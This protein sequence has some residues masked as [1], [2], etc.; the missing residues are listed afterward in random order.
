[1]KNIYF[2]AATAM[3][4]ISLSLGCKKQKFKYSKNIFH[5]SRSVE[6]DFKANNPGTVYSHFYIE[7]S[8]ENDENSKE[9]SSS[10]VG[11]GASEQFLTGYISWGE[12]P[13]IDLRKEVTLTAVIK[14]YKDMMNDYPNMSTFKYQ[15]K[16]KL[17]PNAIYTWDP[18]TQQIEITGSTDEKPSDNNS[19][20][21]N[22]TIGNWERS[23]GGSYL[24]LTNSSV[25]LCNASNGSVFTGTYSTSE[26]K[27][28]LTQGSTSL[29]FYVYVENDNKIRVEQYVSGNYNSTAYYNRVSTYPC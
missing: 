13:E 29:T 25:S 10:S 5:V 3:F 2:V 8:D 1:M 20:T 15:T 17:E 6:N 23:D 4:V 9:I 21:S 24:K 7:I 16:L 11:L 12:K 14:Y 18:V 22:K 27:A 19:N 28:T 26:N